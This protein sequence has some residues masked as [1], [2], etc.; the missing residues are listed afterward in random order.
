MESTHLAL[1]SPAK[2]S[3]VI[4]AACRL[5]AYNYIRGKVLGMLTC[6]AMLLDGRRGAFDRDPGANS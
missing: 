2:S 3:H 6:N 1:Y 4:T 5:F